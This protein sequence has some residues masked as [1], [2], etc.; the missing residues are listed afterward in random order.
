MAAA[1]ARIP[2]KRFDISLVT[3]HPALGFPTV[4]GFLLELGVM[5][6]YHGCCCLGILKRDLT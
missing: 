4:L 5:G 1:V 2:S 6:S 3:V